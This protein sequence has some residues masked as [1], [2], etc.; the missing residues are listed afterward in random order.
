MSIK[1]YVN[2]SV[3]CVDEI[4]IRETKFYI[5]RAIL[6]PESP[7]AFRSCHLIKEEESVPIQVRVQKRSL[8]SPDNSSGEEDS[9]HDEA[10]KGREEAESD[11]GPRS[12]QR[13]RAGTS[14][15]PARR[16]V[17]LLIQ[18]PELQRFTFGSSPENDIV[19]KVD[20][21]EEEGCYVNLWHCR[22]YPDPDSDAVLLNNLSSSIFSIQHLKSGA[23]TSIAPSHDVFI[24]HGTWRITLGE[25]LCFQIRVLPRPSPEEDGCTWSLL[26]SC[27]R[28]LIPYSY[29][30]NIRTRKEPMSLSAAIE[31]IER[32]SKRAVGFINA[33]SAPTSR[34]TS[35]SRTKRTESKTRQS[36]APATA[37]GEN[38]GSQ[39]SGNSTREIEATTSVL[40]TT[41]MTTVFRV[42]RLDG[43]VFVAKVCRHPDLKSAADTWKREATILQKLDHVS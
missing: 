29:G 20:E 18:S 2:S 11:K 34:D 39:E 31:F 40:G 36:A 10:E 1:F 42:S 9:S 43:T 16:P 38:L 17:I 19:L 37:H 4:D 26:S 25:G 30:T 33:R 8:P 15:S 21:A 24:K 14:H 5:T 22:I 7:S 13:R 32:A 35:S 12:T 6:F 28:P 27:E 3:R 23:K 41:R